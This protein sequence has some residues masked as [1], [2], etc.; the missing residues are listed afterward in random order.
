MVLEIDPNKLKKDLIYIYECYLSDNT[1]LKKIADEK[2]R[3][4]DGLWSGD[5]LFKKSIEQAIR[6]LRYIY[7]EPKLSKSKAAEILLG[8]KNER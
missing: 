3:E 4:M 8:L 6:G 1:D 7:L 5:F 2:A